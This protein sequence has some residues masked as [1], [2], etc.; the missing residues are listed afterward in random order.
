M[1]KSRRAEMKMAERQAIVWE[2]K[3]SQRLSDEKIA[4][5][6]AAKYKIFVSGETVRMDIQRV[7]DA[8]LAKTEDMAKHQIAEEITALDALQE[9]YWPIATTLGV[10]YS[11]PV[12]KIV[13]G[14][15]EWVIV[16]TLANVDEAVKAARVVMDVIE[17]RTRLLGIG[18]KANEPQVNILQQKLALVIQRAGLPEDEVFHELTNQLAAY[19]QRVSVASP[20][21]IPE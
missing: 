7:R 8:Y 21:P 10:S 19:G 1:G 18:K 15:E 3:T 14:R 13:N 20:D 6:L 16:E 12:K 5:E 2:L 17:Q 4:K 11:N 9:T